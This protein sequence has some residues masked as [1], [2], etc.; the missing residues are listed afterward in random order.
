MS[1]KMG[2]PTDAPKVNQYRI[3]M[4]DAELELLNQ[5]CDLTGLN[6]ADVIR[7]GLKMVY[8]ANK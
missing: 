1:K 6:K 5:C 2:R 4:T 7:L 8:E 3:R